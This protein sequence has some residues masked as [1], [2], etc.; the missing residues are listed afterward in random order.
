M[1]SSLRDHG[2]SQLLLKQNLKGL[3]QTKDKSSFPFL[4]NSLVKT[5]GNLLKS[6]QFKDTI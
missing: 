4:K 3:L 5:N 6:E 2:N 1:V